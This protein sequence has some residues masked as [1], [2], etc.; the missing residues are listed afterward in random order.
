MLHNMSDLHLSS[1][2]VEP[3]LIGGD[4]GIAPGRGLAHRRLI[5]T[6]ICARNRQHCVFTWC[7]GTC[8]SSVTEADS[9]T[10]MPSALCALDC[11]A[12]A[13]L[14]L[15]AIPP[16][17]GAALERLNRRGT[18]ALPVR[19]W[20]EITWSFRCLRRREIGRNGQV[21]EVQPLK[22]GNRRTKIR[23]PT[24]LLI[25]SKV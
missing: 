8:R 1:L 4:F 5:R 14:D 22:V 20:N 16:E 11:A 23:A 9:F 12:V 21:N 25:V 24:Q 2:C 3:P 18:L 17:L 15:G 7:P 19:G 13:I 6:Q 10:L